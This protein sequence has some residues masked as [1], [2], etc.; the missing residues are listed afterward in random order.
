MI[1]STIIKLLTIAALYGYLGPPDVGV[2]AYAT[3]PDT[4]YNVCLNRVRNG[5]NPQLNCEWPCL[6]SAIEQEHIG[7]WW[8]INVPGASFHF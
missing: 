8:L 4:W 2:G 7:E 5:W 3:E 1:P 6:I